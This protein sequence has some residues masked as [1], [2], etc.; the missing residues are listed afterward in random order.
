MGGHKVERRFL[1]RPEWWNV[2]INFLFDLESAVTLYVVRFLLFNLMTWT[3][4]QC[5]NKIPRN[6]KKNCYVA[7]KVFFASFFLLCLRWSWN[8]IVE[9]NNKLSQFERS[10][11]DTYT[12]SL[13]E[14]I[15]ILY[16]IDSG[17]GFL[18]LNW[19]ILLWLC[20][21]VFEGVYLSVL[22]WVGYFQNWK[23]FSFFFPDDRNLTTSQ[24]SI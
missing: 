7:R 21:W 6:E 14:E 13:G 17:G 1:F 15:M 16:E 24:V 10:K 3:S 9:L 4:L 2:V 11:R 20:M 22:V 12:Q 18:Y 23:P 8:G 5:K 19:G